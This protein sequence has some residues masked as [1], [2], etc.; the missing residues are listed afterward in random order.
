[1]SWQYI[2]S[3]QC[4]ALRSEQQDQGYIKHWALEWLLSKTALDVYLAVTNTQLKDRRG[5]GTEQSSLSGPALS[6]DAAMDYS[7][8]VADSDDEGPAAMDGADTAYQDD[9]GKP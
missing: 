1:M 8:A 4:V 6:A 2:G 3:H 9:A 5:A 7:A